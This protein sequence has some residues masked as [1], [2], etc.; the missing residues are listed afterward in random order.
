MSE[1]NNEH[2]SHSPQHLED[3]FGPPIHVYTRADALRDEV[4]VDVTETAREAGF[5]FPVALTAGV[6]ADVNDIPEQK[7]NSQDPKGRLWD[8]LF[9]AALNCKKGQTNQDGEL[10]FTLIMHVGDSTYYAAKVFF[11]PGDEEEPVLTILRPNED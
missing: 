6:W 10:P 2:S 8:L 7:Q 4:L 9:V 3:L 1:H 11:G 5:R